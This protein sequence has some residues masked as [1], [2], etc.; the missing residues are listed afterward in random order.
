MSIKGLKASE[1]V[2]VYDPRAKAFSEVS[3]AD[4]RLQLESFGFTK[5]EIDARVEALKT[6]GEEV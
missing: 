5:K 6:K 3:I 2:S 4:L 1:V